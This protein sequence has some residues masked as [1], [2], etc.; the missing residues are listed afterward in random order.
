MPNN[1][2]NDAAPCM[3][4]DCQ[5]CADRGIYRDFRKAQQSHLEGRITKAALDAKQAEVRKFATAQLATV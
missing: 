1:T 2:C 3:L 5:D 4:P